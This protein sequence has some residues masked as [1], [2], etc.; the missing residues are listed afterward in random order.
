MALLEYL[1][2]SLIIIVPALLPT[3]S[4]HLFHPTSPSILSVGEPPGFSPPYKHHNRT[5]CR[6]TSR[7]P[8]RLTSSA[9]PHRR[10]DLDWVTSRTRNRTGQRDRHGRCLDRCRFQIRNGCQQRSHTFS[11]TFQ[12]HKRTQQQLEVEMKTCGHLNAYTS[13]EQ[14]VYFAKVFKDD[15][16]KSGGNF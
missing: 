8:F 3:P 13:R 9:L 5:S 11:N 15:V 12:E 1:I 14:T 10:D 16:G 4:L 7:L 2:I 6:D